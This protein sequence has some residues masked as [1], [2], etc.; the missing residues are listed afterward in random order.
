MTTQKTSFG[1]TVITLRGGGAKGHDP[2]T[3]GAGTQVG[4]DIQTPVSQ[5]ANVFQI[6]QPD[7]T[8]IF[9]LGPDGAP[10]VPQTVQAAGAVPITGGNYVITAGSAQALTLAAPTQN[11]TTITI[12]SATAF[13]HTLTATG[14]LQTG[15]AAV[16]VATF[17]AF[18]GAGLT[19]QAYNG[20][21]MVMSSVG[22]TF[23]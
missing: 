2:L 7:G 23:S 5:T 12:K 9:A 1:P 10:I 17:A 11:G 3:V 4:L 18:A 19:L 14:L 6:T 21:W 20:K 8:V 16:N 15:A 22:I 13:A